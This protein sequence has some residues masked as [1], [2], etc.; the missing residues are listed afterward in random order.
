MHYTNVTLFIQTPCTY[1]LSTW[2]A[3]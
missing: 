3:L 1:A 2:E